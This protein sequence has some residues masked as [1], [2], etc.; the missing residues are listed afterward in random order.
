VRLPVTV[1]PAW[2]Q[3][4]V[5]RA[6]GA[7]LALCAAYALHRARTR[8]LSARG[9]ELERLV[10]ERTRDLQE[11]NARIERASLT[12]PLT[13]LGNRRFLERQIGGDVEI[14]LRRHERSLPESD[15]VFFLVDVDHFKRVNDTHG[16]AAG[17]AVLQGVA[18]VLREHLRASDHAVRWGGEEFLAVARFVDRG[19]AGPLAEKLR[20]AVAQTPFGVDD[21]TRLALTCS[22]GFAAFPLS[23]RVP[24]ALGW[25][26]V[27]EAADV[28]LYAAKRG[29][30]NRCVGVDA[31]DA[32]DPLRVVEAMRAKDAGADAPAPGADL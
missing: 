15:L 3:R 1:A 11:A 24:R 19:V 20:A 7:L 18:A 17:D 5:A 12:D 14:A 6:A 25:E 4:R 23:L 10:D 2:H 28:A 21:G 13:G 9:R 30:R 8:R 26:D 27:I 31:A 32:D 22:I 16:H 29:G